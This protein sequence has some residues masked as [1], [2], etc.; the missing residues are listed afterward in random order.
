MVF[1]S[2]LLTNVHLGTHTSDANALTFVQGEKLDTN[3]DGTGQVPNGA[4]Y[5][6][7]TDDSPRI[8]RNGV[9]HPLAT[10]E[11]FFEPQFGSPSSNYRVRAVGKTSDYNFNFRVPYDF[12]SLISAELIM[13][14]P[15]AAAEV[16]SDIDL[17]SEYGSVGELTNQ[18]SESDT[19]T[20]Y[21]LS[22][23]AGEFFALDI[24]PVLSAIS[25]GDFGGINVD[26]NV[27]GGTVNYLG[28]RLRYR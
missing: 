8:R 27:L 21:D 25:A 4:W 18:H 3:G 24:A 17:S 19:I 5:V 15:A 1:D 22:G 20:L 2:R 10:K 7:T 12:A 13:I 16:D 14:V 23:S 11:A 6:N 26:H 9:W 28:I